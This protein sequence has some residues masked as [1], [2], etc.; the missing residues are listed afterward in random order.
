MG[1]LLEHFLLDHGAAALPGAKV[2][3]RKTGISRQESLLGLARP[4]PAPAPQP[5]QWD[6]RA[7]STGIA[8][9]RSAVTSVPYASLVSPQLSMHLFFCPAG[10]GWERRTECQ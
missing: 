7:V 4:P 8:G 1:G 9:C 6:P 5:S 2:P 3:S 10:H